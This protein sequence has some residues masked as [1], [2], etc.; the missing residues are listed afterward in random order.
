MKKRRAREGEE[1]DE[2]YIDDQARVHDE[3]IQQ[4]STFLNEGTMSTREIV[5]M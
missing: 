2:A 4:L 3:S 1:D 5:D